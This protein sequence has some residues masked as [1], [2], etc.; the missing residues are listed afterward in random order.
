[1]VTQAHFASK[2]PANNEQDKVSWILKKIEGAATP[3]IEASAAIF[4]LKPSVAQSDQF[5]QMGCFLTV[6]L[7]KM[8]HFQPLSKVMNVS[9][10][11]AEQRVLIEPRGTHPPSTLPTY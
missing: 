4:A 8:Y 9:S 7:G 2:S 10:D 6:A 11:E 5:T 3:L 1:M